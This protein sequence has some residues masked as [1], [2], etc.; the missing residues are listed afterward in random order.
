MQEDGLRARSIVASGMDDPARLSLCPLACPH[1]HPH[2]RPH[3]PMSAHT[4]RNPHRK[5]Y[6]DYSCKYVRL[7]NS[8]WNAYDDNPFGLNWVDDP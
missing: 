3:V 8:H 1:V 6:D 5:L 2:V 4:L 7:R